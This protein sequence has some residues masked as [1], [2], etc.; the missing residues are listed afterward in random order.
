M[1]KLLS[2]AL[3]VCLCLSLV[4]PTAL[5]KYSE[6]KSSFETF[7]EA[8]VNGPIA[9]A[10][11]YGGNYY[12]NACL[13][14]YP[15]GTTWIYRSAGR[16]SSSNAGYRKNTVLQVYTEQKFETKDDAL[17][18]LQSLGLVD[19]IEEA[20]GSI[21]LVNPIGDTFAAADA[22]AYFLI[23]SATFNLPSSLFGSRNT[24][25]EATYYGGLTY[26]YAIGIDGGATFLN[27]Y[28]ASQFDYVTR[29]GGMVL[30]GGKMDRIHNVAGVIPV[31]LVNP[32]DTVVAKYKAINETDSY[33]YQYDTEIYYNLQQPL[34]KVCVRYQEDVDCAAI[35]HDAY[36]GLLI[37]AMR[38]PVVQEHLYTYANDI[39]ASVS[40]DQAP[41]SLCERTAFF[42]YKTEN[43]VYIE[44]FVDTERFAEYCTREDDPGLFGRPAT[45]G[46]YVTTWYEVVPEEVKNGEVPEHS[47]PL[48]MAYHGAGD[49]PVQFLDEFG[50][51][52]LAD[53]ERVVILAPAHQVVFSVGQRCL[54]PMIDYLLEKYPALDPSRVYVTGYSAGGGAVLH[55]INGNA[56]M[57]AAAV[58]HASTI[59][60]SADEEIVPEDVDL[61][62]M[63]CTSTLDFVGYDSANRDPE[64]ISIEFQTRINDYIVFN[65]MEP[66]V[67][68][69]DKYPQSGFKGEAYDEKLVN[70]EYPNHTWYR[71]NEDG[72][73]LVALNITDFLPHGL[74]PVYGE[75]TWNFLKHY[76]RDLETGE[77]IYM[78]YVQ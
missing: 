16:W 67:Y 7:E 23:Q 70:N 37:K 21:I 39:S 36:Y 10:E 3:I 47:V 44:E 56:H 55:T 26:H 74:Y 51:I 69:F 27:D 2:T 14:D 68:D 54:P 29:L 1:K 57:F 19:I 12:N 49:D 28:V 9:M 41:Y 77:V 73:P 59:T 42:D 6:N 25:V 62:I 61:P 40:W 5:A 71:I 34:Q 15:E 8:C 4:L 45:P 38:Q 75:I 20:R 22:R 72:I 65:G 52:T 24:P 48:I 58:P 63:F 32:T 30:I 33:S 76:K 35:I 43:G 50:L 11:E 18:F 13:A 17:A 31:Y 53:R 60:M 78:P 46:L 64:R 66:N